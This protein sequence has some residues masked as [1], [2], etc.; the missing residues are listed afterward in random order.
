LRVVLKDLTRLGV[1][2]VGAVEA[3]ATVAGAAGWYVPKEY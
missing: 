1:S 2:A 3:D